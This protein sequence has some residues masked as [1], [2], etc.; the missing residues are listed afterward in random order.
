MNKNRT[1]D[2]DF[3]T[4]VAKFQSMIQDMNECEL[5]WDT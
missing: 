2:N 4:H 5:A 1:E 3:D